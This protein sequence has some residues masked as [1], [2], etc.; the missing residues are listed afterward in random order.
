MSGAGSGAPPQPVPSFSGIESGF[1]AFSM[2]AIPGAAYIAEGWELQSGDYLAKK[3][4]IK[5][6]ASLGLVESG[7]LKLYHKPGQ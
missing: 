7:T 6:D 3:E 4:W 5:E 1:P 2:P